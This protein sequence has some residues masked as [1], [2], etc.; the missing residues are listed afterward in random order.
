[1]SPRRHGIPKRLK[2]HK[3]LQYV[4]PQYEQLLLT[5]QSLKTEAEEL[6]DAG[7]TLSN[8]LEKSLLAVKDEAISLADEI[9]E[10][11]TSMDGIIRKELLEMSENLR[12]IPIFIDELFER[13]KK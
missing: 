6:L 11:A 4:K 2:P 13:K 3:L 7:K 10:R 8:E 9:E 5:Y 12:K 1:M